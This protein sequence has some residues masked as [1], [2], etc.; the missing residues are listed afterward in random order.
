VA[1]SYLPGRKYSKTRGNLEAENLGAKQFRRPNEGST[2]LHRTQ[3]A[4]ILR[5][6]VSSDPEPASSTGQFDIEEARLPLRPRTGIGQL[7]REHQ[8]LYHLNKNCGR[9]ARY[10]SPGSLLG[11]R[12]HGSSLR[13][14]RCRCSKSCRRSHSCAA[15]G[16]SARDDPEYC[17]DF[18][19]R[20][21]T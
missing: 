21:S 9:D 12:G 5:L 13:W 1:R 6:F 15:I 2:V 20:S 18:C 7:M 3:S 4:V 10:G 11:W 16:S 17:D 14:A 8:C 19:A